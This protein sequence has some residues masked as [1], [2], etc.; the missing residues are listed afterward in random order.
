MTAN[1]GSDNVYFVELVINSIRY[2]TSLKSYAI[3]TEAGRTC[4][5]VKPSNAT[6]VFLQAPS[7]RV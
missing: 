6:W 2:S 7:V 1:P 4:K 3:P 5:A